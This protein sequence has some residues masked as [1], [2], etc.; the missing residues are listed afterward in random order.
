MSIP[1]H[2]WPRTCDQIEDFQRYTGNE[3]V[4]LTSIA[5]FDITFNVPLH[6]GP[7]ISLRVGTVR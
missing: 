2:K 6:D 5:S 1:L 4:S 7:I 3:T